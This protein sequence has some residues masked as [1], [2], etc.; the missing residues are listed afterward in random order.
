MLRALRARSL[1]RLIVLALA[2]PLGLA[3][4][5]GSTTTPDA[6]GGP[7]PRTFGAACVTVSDT[8]TE[9]DSQICT[10]TFDMIGHPV[11]SQKCT[12]GTDSTCP[13]GS[14]GMKCNMKGYCRP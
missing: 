4:C 8:S 9:C 12:F 13:S 1:A 6:A 7:A 14:A 5:G 11:C 2:V 3:A 10:G